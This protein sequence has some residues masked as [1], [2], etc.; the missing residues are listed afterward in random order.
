M[1]VYSLGYV[2]V[3]AASSSG[4]ALAASALKRWRTAP[5]KNEGAPDVL[6]HA[7]LD[8][9]VQKELKQAGVWDTVVIVAD[10]IETRRRIR[11]DALVS[12]NEKFNEELKTVRARLASLLKAAKRETVALDRSAPIRGYS[13]K[14]I[15]VEASGAVS[16]AYW[17]EDLGYYGKDGRSLE[18]HKKVYE[19]LTKP[20][21]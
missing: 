1:D 5:E 3:G 6:H 19:Y 8:P 13:G 18:D 15:I 7:L 20:V 9:E 12:E 21:E 11:L 4:V 10:R 16:E 2:L 17:K 14:L